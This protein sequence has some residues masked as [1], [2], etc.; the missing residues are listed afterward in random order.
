MNMYKKVYYRLFNQVSEIME[1]IEEAEGEEKEV[2]MQVL[3]DLKDAQ[4][5]AEA[6]IIEEDEEV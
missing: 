1:E 4:G 6:M 3:S 5:R 2:L